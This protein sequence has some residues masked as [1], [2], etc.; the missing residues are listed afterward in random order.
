[1]H[2]KSAFFDLDFEALAAFVEGKSLPKFRAKQICEAIYKKKIF[3]F[4]KI[5]SL[6]LALR[7][8]L[9]DEFELAVAKPLK[10]R[11][12]QDD[13]GKYLFELSDGK[14]VEAVLLEAP[15][16][17]SEKMRKTLC[18]STQVGCAQG[19]RFCASA[20]G[21]FKR[22]LSSAEIVSQLLPFAQGGKFE[23]ENIVVMGMGEPLANF[24]NTLAALKIIN[25][26]FEFGARRITLSTCGIADKIRKLAEMKF[27]FR[28]AIS[29]HGASDAVRSQIMPVNKRFP[30]DE[31]I[32]AAK[33]FAE[34]NGRMITLEYILIEN[35]ND[36]FKDAAALAKIA[37]ELHAHVNLIPYN[38]VIG[39]DWRRPSL[40]RR[41]AFLKFLKDN[42]ASATLRREKGSDIEAACGQLAL[43]AERAK[44]DS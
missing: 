9:A 16:D 7:E 34:S 24:D 1:M 38:T 22:N 12:S 11:V 32:P 21:G 10:K 14:Y 23:F 17:D 25:E 2:G 29:L 19:C 4:S 39:L 31:L 43:V 37:A 8:M 33:E 40:E 44:Q 15:D 13:T 6:P 42:R 28:L 41:Q 27:P 36:T 35:L 20:L 3:D 26:R 18:L 30:L 5:S